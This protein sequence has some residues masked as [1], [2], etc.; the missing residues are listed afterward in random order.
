MATAVM[1]VSPETTMP[2]TYI[3]PINRNMATVE[4]VPAE[5]HPWWEIRVRKLDTVAPPSLIA[6]RVSSRIDMREAGMVNAFIASCFVAF[7]C[8]QG[9]PFPF[10]GSGHAGKKEHDRHPLLQ[11]TMQSVP[12]SIEFSDGGRV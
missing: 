3:A 7:G 8:V 9:Q 1:A 10:F 6:V 5:M 11:N 2:G 4:I 12:G